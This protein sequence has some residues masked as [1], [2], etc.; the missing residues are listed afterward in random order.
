LRAIETFGALLPRYLAYQR[1]RRRPTSYTLQERHLLRYA[2]ELHPRPLAAIDR[3]S[4][5]KLVSALT[6]GIGPAT[7]KGTRDSLNQYFTWLQREGVLDSNPVTFTNIPTT[8]GARTRLLGDEELRKIWAALGTITPMSSSCLSSL[9]LV[10]S[11]SA[12]CHGTRWI[13]RR[14][15]S[16]CRQSAARISGRT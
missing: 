10:G 6:E 2:R 5:A 13:W 14:R 9:A 12:T 11:R 4:I 16:D 3:R 15:R 8:N 7:A 1:T